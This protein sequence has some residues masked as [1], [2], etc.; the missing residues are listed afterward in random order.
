MALLAKLDGDFAC[1]GLVSSPPLQWVVDAQPRRDT[2]A[3]QVDLWSAH[4]EYPRDML[5][6]MT[7][8]KEIRYSSSEISASKRQ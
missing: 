3:F 6:V 7:R 8:E 1:G 4:G 2:P 5:D